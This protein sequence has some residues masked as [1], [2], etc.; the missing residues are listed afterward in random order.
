MLP[1]YGRVWVA[2][3]RDRK[4]RVNVLT[5]GEVTS[6]MMEEVMDAEMKA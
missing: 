4:I 2:E 3:L 1:A 6:V 5:P